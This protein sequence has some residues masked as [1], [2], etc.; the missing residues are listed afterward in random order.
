MAEQSNYTQ[1]MVD[2][3][4]ALY[5]ENPTRET[6]NKLALQYDK[7][8][9]SIIAKL[10]REGVYQKSERL[11]KAG[12]PVVKKEQ[13]VAFISD[14]LGYSAES[15]VKASKNDLIRIANKLVELQKAVGQI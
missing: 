14:Q 2:E 13:V 6:V 7:T 4:V 3:I 9:R 10:S 1:S 15:L 12:S 5:T 8:P 11:N